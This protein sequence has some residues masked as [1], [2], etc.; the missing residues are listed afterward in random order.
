[1]KCVCSYEG[2][3]FI[4]VEM[5]VQKYQLIYRR[6][7]MTGAA[8]EYHHTDVYKGIDIAYACPKCGTLKVE[9]KE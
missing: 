3:D 2:E 5:V 8:G 6:D 4:K 9:V 1:M 7:P